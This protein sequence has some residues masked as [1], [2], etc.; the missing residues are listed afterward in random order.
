LLQRLPRSINRDG[1]IEFHLYRGTPG[2]IDAE[3]RRSSDDLKQGKEAKQNQS[4]GGGKG[5]TPPP[6][7]INVG[8]TD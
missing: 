6:Q 1:L 4:S 3:I 8:F 2:E 5:H 7:K